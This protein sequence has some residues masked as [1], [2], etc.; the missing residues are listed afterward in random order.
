MRQF[1]CL[2]LRAVDKGLEL[3]CVMRT[4]SIAPRF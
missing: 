3:D 2:A 4:A 1:L